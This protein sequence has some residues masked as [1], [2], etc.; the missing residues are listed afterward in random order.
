MYV[1]GIL[2]TYCKNLA[3]PVNRRPTEEYSSLP[4][5]AAEQHAHCFPLHSRLIFEACKS[6]PGDESVMNGRVIHA[7]YIGPSIPYVIILCMNPCRYCRTTL[8]D[9]LKSKTEYGL[10]EYGV[11]EIS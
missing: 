9:T 8:I 7:T 4:L 11:R 5:S 2:R 10:Q 3:G 6:S 1:H